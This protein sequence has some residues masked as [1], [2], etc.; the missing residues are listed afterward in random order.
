[1]EEGGGGGGGGR[2]EREKG[3]GRGR[4]E[5]GGGGGREEGGG[6]REEEERGRGRRGGGGLQAREE[7]EGGTGMR[8]SKSERLKLAECVSAMLT[9]VAAYFVAF[10]AGSKER[11]L[12]DD[13][14]ARRRPGED[15]IPAPRTR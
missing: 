3:G 10:L 14:C 12:D 8:E 1:M 9:A 7:E 4:R 13:E 15:L 2:R 11:S 5:E 6:R